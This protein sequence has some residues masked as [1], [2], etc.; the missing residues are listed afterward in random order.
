MSAS[1]KG[2]PTPC[3]H[4]ETDSPETWNDTCRNCMDGI[5]LT[6]TVLHIHHHCSY[7]QQVMF[8]WWVGN[9]KHDPEGLS[10]MHLARGTDFCIQ[11]YKDHY[12]PGAH[13]NLDGRQEWDNAVMHRLQT[14]T[15]KPCPYLLDIGETWNA[16]C[17]KYF[18]YNAAALMAQAT[19]KQSCME[20][21]LL[22]SIGGA[23]QRDAHEIN[24]HMQWNCSSDVKLLYHWWLTL[25]PELPDQRRTDIQASQEHKFMVPFLKDHYP[26]LRKFGDQ[27]T[28]DKAVTA[29]LME[30]T[31]SLRTMTGM[32]LLDIAHVWETGYK[33]QALASSAMLL[34]PPMPPLDEWP[35]HMYKQIKE[36][37]SHD[38]LLLY[39][40]W[41]GL[42]PELPDQ[43]RSALQASQED[44]FM[45]PFYN[46]YYKPSISDTTDAAM[47]DT[48]VKDVLMELTYHNLSEETIQ[49]WCTTWDTGCAVQLKCCS[50]GLRTDAWS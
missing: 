37:C 6:G 36:H 38:G 25:H 10:G 19:G 9:H 3:S 13:W 20:D 32:T 28:W 47:W 24:R 41:L 49:E 29:M 43:R 18:K 33:V 27:A 1:K 48:A 44:R 50:P 23:N 8:S 14:L 22:E 34:A 30:L 46:K 17:R 45:D 15:N 16:G 42:H 7:Q 21:L 39:H 26:Q 2:W 31:L 40:W 5:D 4:V 12:A 11:F 35:L